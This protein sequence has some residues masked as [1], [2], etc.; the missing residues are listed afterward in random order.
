MFS[1]PQGQLKVAFDQGSSKARSTEPV[2]GSRPSLGGQGPLTGVSRT[3]R[4]LRQQLLRRCCSQTALTDR[5]V[6]RRLKNRRG[7]GGCHGLRV[8]AGGTRG[9]GAGAPGALGVPGQVSPWR[10][11]SRAGGTWSA[12]LGRTSGCRRGRGLLHPSALLPTARGCELPP[13]APTLAGCTQWPPAP[14][15]LGSTRG[16]STASP[17]ARAGGCVRGGAEG[18]GRCLAGCGTNLRPLPPPTR[19]EASVAVR[20]GR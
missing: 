9:A 14:L 6:R 5:V 13:G 20:R 3:P 4:Q 18:R 1:A 16:G 8:T 10:L 12:A 19:C 7:C 2:F 11:S 15:A 17:S